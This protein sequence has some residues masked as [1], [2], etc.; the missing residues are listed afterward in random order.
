MEDNRIAT[1]P[2][3]AWSRGTPVHVT[4]DGQQIPAYPQETVA[5]ALYASGVK[6]YSTSSRFYHPRGM[7]C[8]IGKCSSCMMRVDGMPNTRT[9]VLQVRD[10]IHRSEGKIVEQDDLAHPLFKQ[11]I[12]GVRTDQAGRS[13]N[14]DAGF[15]DIEGLALFDGC[16]VSLL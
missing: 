3:L 4:Y 9:C 12:R 15:T 5:M 11:E 13:G 2:I 1:H 8:A 6:Q 16:H 7:F 14:E 10:G